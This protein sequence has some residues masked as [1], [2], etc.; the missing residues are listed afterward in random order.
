MIWSRRTPRKAT[1]NALYGTIVA[2]ARLPAFYMSY[3]VPDTVEGRFELLVLHHA[4]TARRLA[5]EPATAPLGPA[6]FDHFCR[7]LDH[8]LREMGVGDLTV[9]KRMT[10]FAEA[11]FGRARAYDRALS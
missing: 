1:I 7:D 8:N 5:G 4:L 6:L 10:G 2:Q 3:G 9:P 11:F